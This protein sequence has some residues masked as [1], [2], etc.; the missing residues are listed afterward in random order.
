MELIAEHGL[1]LLLMAFLLGCSAFFSSTETA[2]F[3]LSLEQIRWLKRRHDP[4]SR[5]IIALYEDQSNFLVSVLF[6][7][8]IV[9]VLFYCEGALTA[10]RIAAAVGA[11][12]MPVVGLAVLLLVI[13]FGEILPKAM[14]MAHPL[15][16]IRVT[17]L[18]FMLW[19]YAATPARLLLRYL[20][21]RLEPAEKGEHE[22][23]LHPEELKMLLDLSEKNGALGPDERE[24]LEDIVELAEVRVSE[25]MVPR[26]DMVRCEVNT[27]V[28]EVLALA[29]QHT[30]RFIPVYERRP[31]QLIG[32]VDVRELFL[33]QQSGNDLRAHLKPL[34]YVPE[35]KKAD[36]LLRELVDEHLPM[37]VAV[38]EYGGIAGLVTLEDLV[39]EVVGE[40]EDEFETPDAPL[41]EW[42][43]GSSYRLRGD[44]A[45]REWREL[46]ELPQAGGQEAISQ[47]DTLG[48]FVVYLLGRLPHP[49][50]KVA[51]GNLVFSVEEVRR[52]RIETVLVELANADAEGALT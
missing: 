28:A 11:W 34:K 52:R 7:N 16:L 17:V 29:R 12:A 15:G 46:F 24:M 36:S 38:D 50:D 9:N 44:L 10:G 5:A 39:E 20:S 23:F 33:D 45:F 25:V 40:M 21:A 31:E 41:V 13:I 47:L 1:L 18:P 43:G 42:Q 27:P 6:G 14:G 19:Q 35:T 37:V 8:M 49:G 26:V 2:L 32:V 48:G 3:S 4:G 30:F 22:R 51:Y